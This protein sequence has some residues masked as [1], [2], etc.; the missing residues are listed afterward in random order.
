MTDVNDNAPEWAMEPFPFLAVVS[1]KAA[2]GTQVY[3]LLAVD[4]DE[5]VHGAVEYFL[6]EGKLKHMHLQIFNTCFFPSIL[7]RSSR[8]TV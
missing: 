6:L 4:R 3:K 5:G 7:N 1:P 8:S 2:A